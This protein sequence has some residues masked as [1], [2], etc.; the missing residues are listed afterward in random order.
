MRRRS[1]LPGLGRQGCRYGRRR[2]GTGRLDRRC[3][4]GRRGGLPRGSEILFLDPLVLFKAADVLLLDLR[5]V[6]KIILIIPDVAMCHGGWSRLYDRRRRHG[7][8]GTLQRLLELLCHVR[9][10]GCVGGWTLRR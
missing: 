4:L 9:Q 6:E 8:R 3:R 2:S 1:R 5:R 7:A 10:K